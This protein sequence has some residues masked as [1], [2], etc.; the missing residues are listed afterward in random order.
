M[1]RVAKTPAQPITIISQPAMQ[2]KLNFLMPFA[3]NILHLRESPQFVRFLIEALVVEVF[4]EL[5]FTMRR[6]A[7]TPAQPITIISQPAMQ[8]N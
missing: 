6:V 4:T 2:N 8:N 1:R 7:K 5:W 3:D